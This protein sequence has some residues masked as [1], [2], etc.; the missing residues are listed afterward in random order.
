MTQPPRTP[1]ERSATPNRPYEYET[2]DPNRP[3]PVESLFRD[4]ASQQ[5]S[6]PTPRHYQPS[7][8]PPENQP[9]DDS[10][11]WLFRDEPPAAP[12][13]EGP[14]TQPMAAA[15]VQRPAAPI[16]PAIGHPV[17]ASSIPPAPPPAG[18]PAAAPAPRPAPR[19]RR[20]GLIITLIIVCFLIA[21]GSGVGIALSLAG[22]SVGDLPKSSPSTSAAAPSPGPASQSA[23]GASNTARP[24]AGAV[25][26]TTA[27]VD[28]QAPPAKDSAGHPVSYEPGNMTDG[29]PS[30]AW[31]CDGS[32]VNHVATFGF[33]PSTTIHQVGL[34][35]GYAKV[36]PTDGANR[37]GEYRRITA[38]TW[39]FSDGRSVKQILMD[40]NEGLQTLA[41]PDV[42]TSQVTMKI[43]STTKPGSTSKTRNAVLVSEVAF[44]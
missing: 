5:P 13:D 17:G 19:P 14:V 30:T 25:V 29:D 33:A 40:G 4:P 36:D 18:R 28:C 9:G 20:T 12:V 23:A 35:N 34:I 27:N 22:T 21:I 37:Y 8:T 11:A 24:P 7:L 16:D 15:T 26:P 32:G 31:R 2:T 1:S 38:V 3:H 10:F 6:R 43:E 44:G 39:T 41:V 42:V